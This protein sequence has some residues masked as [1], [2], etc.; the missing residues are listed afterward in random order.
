MKLS[1]IIATLG[2]KAH[3]S[4]LL[5]HLES[6]VRVPDEVIISTPDPS[7]VE[8]YQSDKFRVSYVFGHTGSAVQRNVAL[9][10]AVGRADIV[11]FF[12]DDFIPADDYLAKLE[13]AF[14]ANPTWSVIMGLVVADGARGTGLDWE[15]GMA[16]L[17]AALAE[18][19]DTQ[20][21]DHV[22][23]Y[24]CNMSMRV[25]FVGALRFD[26]RLPLY[27]W[28]E[29]IDLTSQLRRRGRVVEVRTLLG[30]HLG[31][32]SGGRVSG[33]RFGYSQVMNPIY[34]IRKGTVP[35]SFAMN[36]L[37]RNVSANLVKSIWPESHVDR[38]GRL[39][40]NMLAGWHAVTG[41]IQPEY[42]LKIAAPQKS[43]P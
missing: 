22:G 7:H 24:G 25:S 12:D 2:R 26:E 36:L 10:Q 6:Q 33:E 3:V 27:G 35:F 42:I 16:A 9:E 29:D 13:A 8:V 21:I 17:N 1:V 31:A 5:Q 14:A 41:R 32:K 11:C 28:L 30:V 15:E 40:G 23:A 39:R 43:A 19:E 37:M 20:V 34:L 4:R 18:P 38:R